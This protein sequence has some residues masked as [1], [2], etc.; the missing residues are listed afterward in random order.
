M[1]EKVI[2]ERL[3]TLLVQRGLAS[4]RDRAKAYIMA[5][6][7]YVDGVKEI[8]QAQKWQLMQRLQSK[9]WA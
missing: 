5:G 2:K 9:R 8:K 3:D 4:G 6:V 1:T 7:V